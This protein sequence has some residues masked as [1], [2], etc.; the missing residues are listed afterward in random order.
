MS[1]AVHGVGLGGVGGVG[2]GDGCGDGGGGV[3]DPLHLEGVGP[4]RTVPDTFRL[5]MEN[6]DL[7]LFPLSLHLLP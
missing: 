4:M 1:T 5:L 6:D 3:G 7:G 2:C